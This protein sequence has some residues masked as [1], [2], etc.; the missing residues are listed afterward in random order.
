MIVSKL[1]F[2]ISDMPVSNRFGGLIVELFLDNRHQIVI[3]NFSH[4][5]DFGTFRVISVHR[6]SSNGFV[7]VKG[8]W[9]LYSRTRAVTDFLYE[10]GIN[11]GL[12]NRVL[13]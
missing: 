4:G 10:E 9:L 5:I 2:Q 13:A 7:Y 6:S 8:L 1:A 12:L 11:P 3:F